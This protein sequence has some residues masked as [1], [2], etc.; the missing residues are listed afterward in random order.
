MS[1]ILKRN[2]EVR[3]LFDD[4]Y[5]MKSSTYCYLKCDGCGKTY[6][7][8]TSE[9][10]YRSDFDGKTFCSYNCRSHYYHLHAKERQQFFWKRENDLEMRK[11]R[12]AQFEKQRYERRKKEKQI[13]IQATQENAKMGE[14]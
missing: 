13:N 6:K 10:I 14:N 9:N 2:S 7:H 4:E 3:I 1:D 11:L 12:Q 8:Y 5:G